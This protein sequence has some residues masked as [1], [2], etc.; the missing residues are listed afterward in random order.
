MHREALQLHE[1]LCSSDAIF[2]KVIGVH[3]VEFCAKKIPVL[4]KGA[5]YCNI[6]SF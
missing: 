3:A 5:F 2:S 6:M 1:R 4:N